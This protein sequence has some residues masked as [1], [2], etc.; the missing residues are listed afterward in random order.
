MTPAFTAF[1]SA[2]IMVTATVIAV[3]WAPGIGAC[4]LAGS[5]S[6]ECRTYDENFAF[7][8]FCSKFV[9]Y[10]ACVPKYDPIWPN[11]TIPN[12]G[13]RR[14]RVVF[15]LSNIEPGRNLDNTTDDL[16]TNIF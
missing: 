8:P 2:S 6:G 13:D 10:T 1:R 11:H 3:V 16:I 5:E 9:K 4:R 12:N 7:M 15:Q 14:C